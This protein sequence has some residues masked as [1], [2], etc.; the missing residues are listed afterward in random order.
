M[1]IAVA[2]GTGVVGRHVVEAVRAAGHDPVVL[3][4][5]TGVDLATGAGLDRALAGVD[6]VVDVSN[7]M[8]VSRARAVAFF[9]AATGNLLA[10]GKR[11]GV[12]H[13]VALSIV[14]VDRVGYGYYQ[15][16][17]RQE[18]LVL[19]AGE[20]VGVPGSV[21]RA[22][23]FHEFAAQML[24]R[25]GPFA[26]A[27]RMLTQPVAAREVG[28]ALAAL[29]AGEPVGLAPEL[30]GPEQHQMGDLIRRLV[31]ARGLRRLVVPLWMPG[32][33]GKAMTGGGLLPTGPGPRGSQTFDQWLADDAA[34]SVSGGA[35]S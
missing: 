12:A 33:V 14:G 27:P 31:R 13:H 15:G 26:V 18:A 35:G 16:K 30:A 9:E 1:R 7:R 11:A 4:R 28:V 23:Q 32:A 10:A 20:S 2:G 29:A 34:G 6:A 25:G 5:S 24:E 22:T 19:A 17:L 3:A 21:L 8:T